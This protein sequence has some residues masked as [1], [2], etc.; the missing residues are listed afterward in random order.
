MMQ[1]RIMGHAGVMA[2]I[3]GSRL[4]PLSSFCGRRKRKEPFV[5][6]EAFEVLQIEQIS[7]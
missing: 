3:H 4:S 7:Y 6:C 5:L 1:I 2:G